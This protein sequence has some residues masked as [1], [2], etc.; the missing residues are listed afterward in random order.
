MDEFALASLSKKALY[1]SSALLISLTWIGAT[2]N[3]CRADSGTSGQSRTLEAVERKLFCQTYTED[4]F[5]N[6]LNRVEKRVFGQSIGGTLQQRLDRL[7]TV[8]QPQ[9]EPGE[10]ACGSQASPASGAQEAAQVPAEPTA[11]ASNSRQS[12]PT[13]DEDE[14]AIERA[15]VSVMAAKEEE[16]REL[17]ADGVNLW[18]AGRG[19]EAIQKFEQAIRLDPQNAEAHFSMGIIEETQGNLVEAASSYRLASKARPDHANYKAAIG[20]VEKK[21]ASRQK[22]ETDN[23]DIRRLAED[24]IAAYKRGEYLSALDLYKVLDQKTPNQHLVKYNI[25]TVYLVLKQPDR[26]IEYYKQA[27]RLNPQES[28]YAEAC[29]GLEVAISRN[30]AQLKEQAKQYKES[31]QG[32]QTA[33]AKQTNQ[34]PIATYGILGRSGSGGVVITTIGIASRASKIGIQQGDIIRAVDGTVVKNISDVNDILARKTPGAPVQMVIQRDNQ[35]AQ[36]VL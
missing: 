12:R 33:P 25:G 16:I 22:V 8:A 30:K 24:A 2:A 14:C 31:T 3:A 17:L 26:A 11:T 29:E 5:E 19:Q 32:M 13:P 20:A 1:I 6:R 9:V 35:L 7:T 15:R 34:G 23:A 28:K 36:I 27:R 18:R 10:V 4:D 21:L